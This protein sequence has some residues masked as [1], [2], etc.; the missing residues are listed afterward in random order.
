[1]IRT[2]THRILAVL[3]MALAL[4][5]T[6]TRALG[7]ATGNPVVF[8]AVTPCRLVD[9]RDPAGPYGGPKF[10]AGQSRNFDL[11]SSPTCTGI[12]A[13]VFA[14]SVNFTVT[15]TDGPGFLLVFPTGSPQRASDGADLGTFTVGA[16]PFG[17]AFD[18]ANIWVTNNGSNTVSK[19]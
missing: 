5:F 8:T 15:T 10:A 7:Q 6:A 18:G 14:Y 9:T 19:R 3:L 13:N 12:P 16:S 2:L 17:V 1:M 4:H 11:N